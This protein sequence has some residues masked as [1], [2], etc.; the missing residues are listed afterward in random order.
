M[1]C[2][3]DVVDFRWQQRNKIRGGA[4]VR[5]TALPRMFCKTAVSV[6]TVSSRHALI[7]DIAMH[8]GNATALKML[9]WTH[10]GLN[11]GTSAC[12][13]DVIPLHHVPMRAPLFD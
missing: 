7:G 5:E 12:E 9:N 10:W 6:A 4:V 13:A 2:I 1:H 8:G 11:P 3:A